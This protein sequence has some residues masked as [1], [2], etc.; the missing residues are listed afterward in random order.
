MHLH[1]SGCFLY[2]NSFFLFIGLKAS[3]NLEKGKGGIGKGDF[4]CLSILTC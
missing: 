1:I 2:I 3:L 4:Y